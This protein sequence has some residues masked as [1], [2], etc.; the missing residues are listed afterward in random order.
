[1]IKWCWSTG[2]MM[3]RLE[4]CAMSLTVVVALAGEAVAGCWAA[5]RG[6]RLTSSAVPGRKLGRLRSDDPS[7]A[8]PEPLSNCLISDK[9]DLWS[10][11][12]QVS[13]VTK[14][15]VALHFDRITTSKHQQPTRDS[16]H[17]SSSTVS[18]PRSPPH[19]VLSACTLS[20]WTLKMF[21][22]NYDNDSVTL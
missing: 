2:E 16:S 5:C 19:S 12:H 18:L 20:H 4:L 7:P 9:P 15:S 17:N 22:N 3:R 6:C 10:A 11:S 1:M 14:L 8:R 21:R 13:S